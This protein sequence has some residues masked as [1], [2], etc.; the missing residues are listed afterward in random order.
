MALSALF[1]CARETMARGEAGEADEAGTYSRRRAALLAR[2]PGGAAREWRARWHGGKYAA[3]RAL[4]AAA[5]VDSR[6]GAARARMRA[7]R[8]PPPVTFSGVAATFELDGAGAGALRFAS[9]G[10]GRAVDGVPAASRLAVG[11]S[12]GAISIF[13]AFGSNN[14]GVPVARQMLLG[15]SAAVTDL[16]WS[17][18][19]DYPL[20]ASA[21]ADRSL[22]IW[23]VSSGAC[24]RCVYCVDGGTFAAVR[25]APH[26]ANLLL[27]ASDRGA[28]ALINVSTGKRLGELAPGAGGIEALDASPSAPG[29]FVAGTERGAVLVV[30]IR[31]NDTTLHVAQHLALPRLTGGTAP[32][33]SVAFIDAARDAPRDSGRDIGSEEGAERCHVATGDG[34]LFLVRFGAAAAARASTSAAPAL[35]SPKE[36]TD[37]TLGLAGRAAAALAR[38]LPPS[39]A[40]AAAVKVA[41][42]ADRATGK[43]ARARVVGAALARPR[44]RRV[45][46]CASPDDHNHHQL[47]VVTGGED[48]AVSTYALEEDSLRDAISGLEGSAAAGGRGA[49]GARVLS[50]AVDR[51]CGH[52]APVVDVCWNSAR[53]LLASADTAGRVIVWR[54]ATA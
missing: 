14:A 4:C 6:A 13:D 34:G 35:P 36:V 19:G 1:L 10:G 25:F 30:T 16:D 44:A 5:G 38:R 48:M 49:H 23:D 32:V 18:S 37:A 53:T 31:E 45:R 11:G 52:A 29:V 33:C 17:P 40:R 7:P 26:N 22:R 28:L 27:A 8:R 3:T 50:G 9:A 12:D 15:H 20:L 51:L 24:V 39:A 47:C 54:R 41:A 43:L 2:S 46:A 42:S 21:A